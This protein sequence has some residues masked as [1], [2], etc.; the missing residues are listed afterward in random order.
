MRKYIKLALVLSTIFFAVHSDNVKVFAE[1]S[2]TE[3]YERDYLSKIYDSENGLEGTT[4]NCICADTDGFLWF[5]GYTGLYR[6]DGTEF[7]KYLMDGR[8]LPVNDIVQDQNGDLW[9]GTN[10]EGVYRFD[11]ENFTEYTLNDE[12]QGASV[13]NKLFLDSNNI[14]WVGT[15]AGLFTIDAKEEEPEA[16][17][18]RKFSNTIIQD[19]GELSSGEAVV[20][21][22]TGEVFVLQDNGEQLELDLD[23][24]G[25]EGVPRCCYGADDGT[26][27]IGTSGETLLKIS[28][29]G[30]VLEEIDGNG[31]SSFNEIYQLNDEEYWICSDTGI[32]I[33]N[34][35]SVLPLELS[36]EDSIEEG[37]Q[38]YQGNFWFV[39]SR[40]GVMQLYENYFSDLGAYW[41]IE[42][43]VNSIQPYQDR[44]YVGCDDG[45]YCF[46]GKE[47]V[48]D[49][50]VQSCK[51][52]RIRQIYLD[53]DNNLW[54]STY[55][56]G[57]KMMDADGE[58]TNYNAQNSTLET[59][60]IR[61]IWQ[62]SNKEILIGTEDGLYRI[63][64]KGEIAKYTD[65]SVLNTKRI[66]DVKECDAGE[67]Y[68]S[69]DGYGIY[70]IEDDEVVDMYSKQQGLLS[71][72]V[73]KI[74]PSEDMDGIWTVTGEGIC[75]IDNM[76]KIRK[77]TGISVA[78]SLDLLL[79][80]D[81]KAVVLAGNGFFEL[82]EKDL[83][84]ED[85]SYTYLNKQDGLPV[86]FTANARNTIQDGILYMCGTTGAVSIDLNKDQEEKPIKLYM[87]E[88]TEDGKNID[89]NKDDIIF[90]PA[91]HRVNI[92]VRMINFVHR[93]VYAGYFLDGM[94]EKET[95]V[96]D[97]DLNGISYTNLP[98]GEYTYEY[99]I[100]DA[101][102]NKCLAD[103]S[104]AFQK[105][106]KFW[107]QVRVRVLLGVF[108]LG[109]LVLLFAWA[110]N[111]REKSVK[112]QCYMEFLQEK[113]AEIS[114]LAYKDLVT[115]VYNRNYFEQEK[116]KIDLQ[117]L[118]AL[119]SVSINHV[120]Y[121]KSKYGIFYTEGIFRKGVQ[122]M[123]HCAKEEIKICRVSENIFYFWFMEP[124]QLETYIYDIKNRFEQEG[125]KEGMPLSFSVGAIYNNTVGKENID[126]LID[127]CGKMRLLDEKHA[128][129]RFIEGK[130]K[131]L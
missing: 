60:K 73:M 33:L 111:L 6:Y 118:S 121:F 29:T 86:D 56:N 61:C 87:N 24:S 15:K 19:I 79:T 44:I 95:F 110:I 37:C 117:K 3:K 127:R 9:I 102:T 91:A 52:Q 113:E 131:M 65:N 81:G 11:G 34:D 59:N 8:A 66:L 45:L 89:F 94:D 25:D 109:A 124:I 64:Q 107:E 123:Q 28:S 4:A 119:V 7:K 82:L 112:K 62:R 35:D 18:Y 51:G 85:I 72:V 2:E 47:R 83:L 68:A 32:G 76:G 14:V 31:L 116:E 41:N 93:E 129:T 21:Q 63:D 38:D 125:E 80:D 23:T 104:V 1:D 20:I 30:D 97:I 17:R 88:V 40:Q 84:E 122:V 46:E 16:E 103:F 10:G 96:K 49:K 22:K 57:I 48:R 5:G 128:E 105:N 71:N 74:V 67:I 75:F 90:S 126:E 54:V 77:V 39:S 78:N 36:F 55:Q 98:G 120:D 92:D 70:K 100:Y 99:R 27:Y 114:K 53:N 69:T 13:I 42:Q 101:D 43:T 12:E 50:L 115:G 130:M 108:A 58:V 26:F 106:Y